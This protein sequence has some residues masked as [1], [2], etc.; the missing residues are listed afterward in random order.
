[1]RTWYLF[2]DSKLPYNMS[3]ITGTKPEQ[4]API[5]LIRALYN[6]IASRL[7]FVPVYT[8]AELQQTRYMLAKA[9]LVVDA[10]KFGLFFR[11]NADTS[12]ADDGQSTINTADDVP[13]RFKRRVLLRGYTPTSG[14][15]TSMELGSVTYDADF[16]HVKTASST[17]QKVPFRLF[18]HGIRVATTLNGGPSD[19]N[20]WAKIATFSTVNSYSDY[21]IILSVASTVNATTNCRN[22]FLRMSGRRDVAEFTHSAVIDADLFHVI[23][24]VRIVYISDS[25]FELWIQKASAY[26]LFSFSLVN[27][28]LGIGLAVSYTIGAAWQ[29][30]AP[31][32]ANPTNDA[33]AI[34][35][36]GQG[37]CTTATRP[38]TTYIRPGYNIWDT[39]IGKQI[40]WNGVSWRDAQGGAV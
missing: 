2:H 32:S 37:N 20:Y 17:I 26:S 19:Q 18:S 29:L 40:F 24:E 1:M 27:Q 38:L 39:T 36:S 30:A 7:N 8:V 21:S 31:T 25:S 34:P 13:V 10:G 28:S 6:A 9:V 16:L 12:S 35:T 33:V 4:V 3:F 15:D 22:G 5:G 23:K 14:T 11:D